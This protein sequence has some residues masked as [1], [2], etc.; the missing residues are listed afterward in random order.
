MVRE[1]NFKLVSKHIVNK[2]TTFV[3]Y[4]SG[5]LRKIIKITIVWNHNE[6]ES[7]PSAGVGGILAAS[8]APVPDEE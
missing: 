7:E 3:Y 6:W 5:I 8:R 1:I 2:I 4:T